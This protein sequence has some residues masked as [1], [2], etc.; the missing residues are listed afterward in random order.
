VPTLL[1]DG[2]HAITAP[3]AQLEASI[4]AYCNANSIFT[5]AALVA[6]INNIAS[7]G[8]NTGWNAT[9]LAYERARMLSEIY[10]VPQP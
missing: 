2:Q 7:T 10:I 5:Q 8:Q 3:N 9:L 1:S 6:A 4:A